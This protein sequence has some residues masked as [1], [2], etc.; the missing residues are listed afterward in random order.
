[1]RA[2]YRQSELY[3]RWKRGDQDRQ[4]NETI[5][6]AHRR[7]AA[8]PQSG[9]RMLTRL[10]QLYERSNYQPISRDQIARALG[11]STL[12]SWD[13]QL[14][15]RLCKAR[16]ISSQREPMPTYNSSDGSINGRGWRYIYTMDIDT[17]LMLAIIAQRHKRP[18]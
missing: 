4:L 9:Q 7:A 6:A 16:F 15:Q 3:Q 2:I 11:R 5:S 14:I 17:G 1:M 13:R 8:L 10:H 18:T 12:S